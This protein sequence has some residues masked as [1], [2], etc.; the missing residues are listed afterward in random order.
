M[1]I[2]NPLIGS[3]M[4]TPVS[5]DR[6]Q[7]WITD[8]LISFMCGTLLLIS[9]K[10]FVPRLSG[11][12]LHIFIASCWSQSNSIESCLDSS[13]SLL[14]VQTISVRSIVL[15]SDSYNGSAYPYS[16][17]CLFGDLHMST[18]PVFV[19]MVYLY[20]GETS[21]TFS[22]Q[23]AIYLSSRTRAALI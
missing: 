23:T 5:T 16:L 9:T 15:N 4:S 20:T 6:C 3:S 17:L 18:V 8:S 22:S 13:G 1:F 21:E 2:R 11:Q 14:G 7:P 19:V 12:K 10:M